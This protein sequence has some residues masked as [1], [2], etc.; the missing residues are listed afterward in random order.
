M[1]LGLLLCAHYY[2]QGGKPIKG[3][4][5]RQV[6]KPASTRP[7]LG[8]ALDLAK[9]D[10]FHDWMLEQAI[11]FEGEPWL[12][13]IPGAVPTVMLYIPEAIEEVMNLNDTFI[14]GKFLIERMEHLVGTGIMASDGERWYRQRKVAA[15]FFTSKTLRAFVTQS[16]K[17]N[18]HKIEQTFIEMGVG[19]EL[20][21]IGRDEP[22]PFEEAFD[23]GSA[24]TLRRIRVPEFVWKLER[25]LNKRKTDKSEPTDEIKSVVELFVEQSGE[26]DGLRP[27]A[28]VDFI[29]S[30]ML[31]ARDTT[32]LTLAWL[33]YELGR[34]P[35]IEQAIRKEMDE[36]LNV[37]KDTYLTPDRIRSLTMLEATIK[38][39]LRYHPVAPLFMREASEDTFICGDILV[40]KGQIVGLSM[41]SIYRN[42]KTWGPDA[43]EFKPQRWIDEKTGYDPQHSTDAQLRVV[44]AN[45]LHKYRFD[46]DPSNDGTYVT[47]LSLNLKYP[48]MATVRRT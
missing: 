3:P 33:F 42:P 13:T 20:D 26:A 22:H 1:T 7:V 19:T 27:E 4:K 25:W 46:I 11:Q 41:Y 43:G 32:T 37:T 45:L 12:L 14:K 47:G 30:F 28:L 15:K 21:W 36:K 29:L 48:L 35:D 31:A 8:N 10:R 17:K 24:L 2:V 18:L 39:T 34:N 9:E 38:E 5:P 6:P 44:T 23:L 40:K 16:M